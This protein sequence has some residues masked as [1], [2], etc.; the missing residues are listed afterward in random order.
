M[1]QD[2][3]Q[4]PI[5][6]LEKHSDALQSINVR[7]KISKFVG[8][9][10][11]IT[12]SIL[13]VATVWLALLGPIITFVVEITATGDGSGMY[14]GTSNLFLSLPPIIGATN[15]TNLTIKRVECVENFVYVSGEEICYPNCLWS[16]VGDGVTRKIKISLAIIDVLSLVFGSA[17]LMVWII[18]SCVDRKKRRLHYDFQLARTSLFMVIICSLLSILINACIDIMDRSILFCERSEEEIPFLRAQTALAESSYAKTRF[19]TGLLG[20]VWMYLYTVNL[21][22]IL[23][24]L[25]NILVI[26]FYPNLRERFS[27]RVLI[28]ALQCFIS[29]GLN[30]IPI[31]ITIALRPESA[32]KGAYISYHI[33]IFNQWAFVFFFIVPSVVLPCLV[34]SLVVLTVAKMRITSFHSKEIT[35]SS[36]KLTDLEKRLIGYSTFLMLLMFLHGAIIILISRLISGYFALI[37]QFILCITVNSPIYA[38]SS[39]NGTGTNST[40]TLYR[41]NTYGGVDVCR[42]LEASANNELPFYIPVMLMFY[43]RLVWIPI[44]IIIVPHI[45]PRSL[46]NFIYRFR[47]MCPLYNKSVITIFVKK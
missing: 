38:T 1:K 41:E 26:V 45:S 16:P 12:I 2:T 10:V 21:F 47:A 14:P 8:K 44:F 34:L 39:L 11:C 25:I 28:F 43:L 33:I 13:I 4:N 32:Y 23:F 30:L 9:K 3:V 27:K 18:M 42:K 46:K 29:F 20:A 35:G 17:T 19:I 22:W 40:L 5:E 24:S 36:I 6:L 37:S 7:R 31:A 15:Y